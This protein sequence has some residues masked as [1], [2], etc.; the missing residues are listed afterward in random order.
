[1]SLSDEQKR[2]RLTGFG[3]SEIGALAGLNPYAGPIDVYRA[4]TDPDYVVPVTAPMERGIFFEDPTAR[5]YAHRT[6]ATLRETGTLVHPTLARVL[7]TPDRLAKMPDGHEVDVSIKVP[8]PGTV[9]QWGT[10]GTDEVPDHA[11]AQVQWELLVLEAR[12]DI[13]RAVIVAP[14]GGDLAVYNVLA[15]PEWQGHLVEIA[16]RFWK[17]HIE[18]RIPP[19]VD[20]SKS[21]ANWLKEAYP[22]ASGPMMP[23][24]GEADILMRKLH[25]ARVEKKR[26][27]LEEE[28]AKNRLRAI[29]GESEGMLGNGW[30]ITNRNRKDSAR[31]DWEAVAHEMAPPA[32]IVRKHTSAVVGGRVFLPTWEK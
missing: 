10:P 28:L 1:M 32:D 19:P 17:D 30:R 2:L 13:R 5:W 14:I 12:Y 24:T 23:A 8:G 26:L 22:V 21:S 31:T 29:I 25:A 6:G 16:H 11:N 18:K 27:E 9:E 15:D 20:G 3:G 7:C 4:K